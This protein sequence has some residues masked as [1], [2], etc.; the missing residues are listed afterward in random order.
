[1]KSL[2][3]DLAEYLTDDDMDGCSPKIHPK[4]WT[5]KGTE[6]LEIRAIRSLGSAISFLEYLSY[7]QLQGKSAFDWQM[8]ASLHLGAFGFFGVG[9]FTYECSRFG[10]RLGFASMAED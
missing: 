10:E 9:F 3:N 6:Q 4:K 8:Y 5:A 7:P 1:M 2:E